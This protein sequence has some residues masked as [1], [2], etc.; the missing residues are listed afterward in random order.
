MHR[1]IL[2]IFLMSHLTLVLLLVCTIPHDDPDP[3]HN[4]ERKAGSLPNLHTMVSR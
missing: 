1:E 3:H 2:T 4:Y